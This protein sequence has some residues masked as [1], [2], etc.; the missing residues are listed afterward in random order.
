V[1]VS[2]ADQQPSLRERK[3][4]ATRATILAKAERLFDQHGYDRVTVAQIADAADVSVKTLFVYFRSKEDLAFA[5]T[6]L[7]DALL[8]ALRRREPGVSHA[9]A[10]GAVLDRELRVSGGS[11]LE[12]YH[13]GIGVAGALRSRLLR[14][15]ADY[16]D[17]VASVL[18]EQAGRPGPDPAMRLAATQLI[19]IVRSFTSP[20]VRQLAR[21]ASE[22]EETVLRTWLEQAVRQ[23]DNGLAHAGS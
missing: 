7:L 18:A 16:E 12:A 3:K 1:P 5:D 13:R 6:S 20:E 22:A 19:G 4:A 23:V 15:W 17:A 9:A 8:T 14:M 11:G 21:D 2:A 10:V